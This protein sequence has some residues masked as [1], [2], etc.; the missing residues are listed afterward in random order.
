MRIL[1]ISHVNGRLDHLQA[2]LAAAQSAQVGAI[3]VLGNLTAAAVRRQVYARQLGG[4]RTFGANTALA[5]EHVADLE[6]YERS[7]ELLGAAGAP[8]FLI[9]GEYDAPLATLNQALQ[10]YRGNAPVYKVHRKAVYLSDGDVVAGFGGRLVETQ[11]EDLLLLHLPAWEVRVAFE[12][13]AMSNFSFQSARHRILLFATPPRG[14]QIDR[15]AGSPTG[16]PLLNRIIQIYQPY[17]VCCAGPESGRGVE[18]IDGAHVVNPGALAAGS[19]ALIDIDPLH[20][21]LAYLDNRL[22]QSIASGAT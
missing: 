10:M 2:V 9:P 12:C 17:L 19:Y 5:Q 18:V 1:A 4:E 21:H 8:I 13:L 14:R 20:V 16:L 7:L 6:L 15:D 22:P 11:T 3:F